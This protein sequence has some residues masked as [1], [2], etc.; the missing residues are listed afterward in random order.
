MVNPGGSAVGKFP[1]VIDVRVVPSLHWTG[2]V[3]LFAPAPQIPHTLIGVSYMICKVPQIMLQF[4][5]AALMNGLTKDV[6]RWV[7]HRQRPSE[8]VSVRKCQVSQEVDDGQDDPVRMCGTSGD[9]Y[10]FA[11]VIVFNL[12]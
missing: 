10:R 11:I 12:Y 3:G 7:K 2:A 8:I 6:D 4:P 1:G 9:K 5:R